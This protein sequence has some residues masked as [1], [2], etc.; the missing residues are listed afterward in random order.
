MLGA[1]FRDVNVACAI[2]CD[3]I[4]VSSCYA[5]NEGSV[6]REFLYSPVTGIGDKDISHS[7]E[8]K[9]ARIVKLTFSAAMPAFRS[10]DR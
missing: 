2:N 7:I 3:P 4:R 9:G 8:C 1:Y 5:G 6:W 10:C